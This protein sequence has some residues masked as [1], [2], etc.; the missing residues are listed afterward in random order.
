[1]G[2]IGTVS[3]ASTIGNLSTVGT[4]YSEYCGYCEYCGNCRYY[5]IV[6]F[7]NTGVYRIY[8]PKALGCGARAKQGYY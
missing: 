7:Q 1:M 5:I 2:N 8:N 6:R 3:T 4:V